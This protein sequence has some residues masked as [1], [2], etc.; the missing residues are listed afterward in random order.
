MFWPQKAVK[1]AVTAN[2]TSVCEIARKIGEN[3]LA[4]IANLIQR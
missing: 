3:A 1:K 2:A 4:N